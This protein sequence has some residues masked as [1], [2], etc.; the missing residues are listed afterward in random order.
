MIKMKGP[1]AVIVLSIILSAGVPL[2]FAQG[3]SKPIAG[4]MHHA[5]VQDRKGDWRLDGKP[6]HAVPRTLDRRDP[7]RPGGLDPS[8]N[9]PPT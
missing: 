5:R 1:S 7:S 3:V 2:S 4:H 9:P 8:F 6:A